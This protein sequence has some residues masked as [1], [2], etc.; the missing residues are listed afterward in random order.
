MHYD[1]TAKITEV[2]DESTVL[3]YSSSEVEDVKATVF[4]LGA[5]IIEKVD[6]QKTL[7]EKECV[8]VPPCVFRLPKVKGVVNSILH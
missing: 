8:A 6:A 1:V 5:A 4:C 7:K 2:N 3:W